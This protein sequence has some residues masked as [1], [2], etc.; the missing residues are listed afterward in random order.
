MDLP[1]PIACLRGTTTP[2]QKERGAAQWPQEGADI[3]RITLAGGELTGRYGKVAYI[4]KYKLLKNLE[5]AF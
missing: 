2:T 5:K 1:R 3:T 4:I